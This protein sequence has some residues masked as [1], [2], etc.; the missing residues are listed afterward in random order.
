MKR[1]TRLL[2]VAVLGA[3]ALAACGDDDG[4]SVRDDSLASGSETDSGS[5]PAS[6]SGSGS[7]VAV[8]DPFGNAADA[9]TTVNVTLSEWKIEMST[10]L[11]PE[12]TIH[13]AIENAG[14]EAH[15]MVIVKADSIDALPLDDEGALDE[16]SLPE[17]ALIG[18]VEGFP[19]GETCDGTFAL[20]AGRYVAV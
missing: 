8:C 2:L 13:F 20:E 15:E 10:L 5:E 16:E 6:G 19:A 9:D 7:A 11:I 12:G 1:L 14:A 4:S 18:E 3:G 17:G